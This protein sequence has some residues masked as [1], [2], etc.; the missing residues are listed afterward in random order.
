MEVSER[1]NILGTGDMLSHY[2]ILGF[3]GKGGFGVTYLALDTK[4]DLKVAI[5]EYMPEQVAKRGADNSIQPNTSQDDS[6]FDWGLE[7]FIKEAQTLAKFNHPNIVRVMAVLELNGTAYMVME[8]ER[9]EELK[10]FFLRPE[11]RNDTT[12]KRILRPIIDGL[13]EVH[14]HG[15]IHRDIKPTNII[16][17]KNGTP[18]LLDFGS[19]RKS[20]MD[21]TSALTAL[22]SVGY[23]PLEQYNE[24]SDK[25]QGPWTDIYAL[26]AVLYFTITGNPPVASTLRGSAVLNDRTDP[27]LSLQSIRPEGFSESFCIAIDWALSF[28]IADRPQTLA[29]WRRHLLAD[30]ETLLR[31]RPGPRSEDDLTLIAPPKLQVRQEPKHQVSDSRKHANHQVS[32]SRKHANEELGDEPWDTAGHAGQRYSEPLQ[33]KTAG[34]RSLWPVLAIVFLAASGLVIWQFQSEI[35]NAFIG[36]QAALAE[37]AA[38]QAELERQQVEELALVRLNWNASRQRRHVRPSLNVSK[39]RRHV[40]PSWNASK[41]RPHVRLSCRGGTSG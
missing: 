21:T 38:R 33:A 17:R 24:T 2:R 19:A 13:T 1:I 31:P 11:N 41:Q 10:H 28:K 7:R 18:V 25:Q 20:N 14:R 5:K 9:G 39:Q 34:K 22:V 35:S 37:T 40:R 29:E 4:L 32:K 26:A 8:Y 6:I 36:D 27:L 12:L 15:Y 3:L 23:A 30:D 16:I